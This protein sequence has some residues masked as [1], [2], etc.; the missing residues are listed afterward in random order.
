VT[1]S[2]R[3]GAEPHRVLRVCIAQRLGKR[4]RA[5]RNRDEVNV[6]AH[7]AIRPHRQAVPVGVLPEKAQV[8]AAG[9]R[10]MM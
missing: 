1:E 6:V 10:Y 7:E 3:D 5:L 9:P 4:I 8:S 2:P